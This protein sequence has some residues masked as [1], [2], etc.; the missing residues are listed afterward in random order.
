MI[1]DSELSKTELAPG[2]LKMRV[3]E[4][5]TGVSMVLSGEVEV[6]IIDPQDDLGTTH[7]NKGVRIT[8]DNAASVGA[9]ILAKFDGI[10]VEK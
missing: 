5:L 6:F 9:N 3:E 1:I 4:M 7:K 2:N 10:F 8:P